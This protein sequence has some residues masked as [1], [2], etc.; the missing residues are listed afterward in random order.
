MLNCSNIILDTFLS[1]D[2]KEVFSWY[3]ANSK[4]V[5]RGK[6][7]EFEAKFIGHFQKE[8]TT[9]T[10]IWKLGVSAFLYESF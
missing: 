10:K 9:F 8:N 7:S 5:L 4:Q 6:I 3:I 2:P 1:L